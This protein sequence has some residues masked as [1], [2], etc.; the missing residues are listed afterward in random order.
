[1]NFR[2]EWKQE[3]NMSDLIALK[4][5]LRAIMVF[6]KGGA[7]AIFQLNKAADNIRQP[8]IPFHFKNNRR[9][10]YIFKSGFL[11][12]ITGVSIFDTF[13]ALALALCL[14][15]FIFFVYK[16]TFSGVMYSSGFAV[17]DLQPE[18]CRR[19]STRKER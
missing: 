7:A 5:S 11:E 16:R 8:G 2:H 14:G 9:V 4:P 13:T 6:G 19:L 10:F 12:N 18:Q 15:L 3:I 17:I 1:M